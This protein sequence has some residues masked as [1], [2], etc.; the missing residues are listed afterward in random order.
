MASEALDLIFAAGNKLQAVARCLDSLGYAFE[1][2]GNSKVGEDL[3]RYAQS[4]ANAVSWVEKG[5]GMM[6]D[7]GYQQSVNAT[8]NMLKGMMAMA[9]EAHGD[10]EA[11]VKFA[12]PNDDYQGFELEGDK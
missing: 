10:H 8:G 9:A 2:T 11:A 7:Q 5:T 3:H 4:I 12:K 1:D 6:V